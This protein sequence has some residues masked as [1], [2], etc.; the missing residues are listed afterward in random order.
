MSRAA[1]IAI[2]LAALGGCGTCTPARKH[3]NPVECAIIG[4][5]QG[6]EF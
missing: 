4:D 2:L 5:P 1:L 6:G 3:T